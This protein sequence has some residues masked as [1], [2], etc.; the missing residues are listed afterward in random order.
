MSVI[1]F[2]Y[3]VFSFVIV[4]FKMAYFLKSVNISLFQ[5]VQ[6]VLYVYV[7]LGL[8]QVVWFVF[9]KLFWTLFLIAVSC[10]YYPLKCLPTVVIGCIF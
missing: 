1:F 7:G 2:D 5:T 3:F 6:F 8:K 4:P 9:W 10:K